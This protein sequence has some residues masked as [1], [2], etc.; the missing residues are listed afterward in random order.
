MSNPLNFEKPVDLFRGK[1][2]KNG[3]LKFILGIHKAIVAIFGDDD[4]LY[5]ECLINLAVHTLAIYC[6][7]F[8]ESDKV[9]DGL[10]EELKRIIPLVIEEKINK[11]T[12][13]KDMRH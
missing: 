10:L 6:G 8:K 12:N 1:K 3:V 9:K 7:Q 4:D 11:D 5:D 13:E 2:D